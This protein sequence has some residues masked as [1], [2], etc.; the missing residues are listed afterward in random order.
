MQSK[1]NDVLFDIG[2]WH[3]ES[4]MH[5]LLRN[6][7]QIEEDLRKNVRGRSFKYGVA[8]D[9]QQNAKSISQVQRK[10]FE[11]K[12]NTLDPIV[13]T[14]RSSNYV[15]VL[16]ADNQK[17]IEDGYRQGFIDKRTHD[18]LVNQFSNKLMEARRTQGPKTVT[19]RTA[20][21]DPQD[22][23]F[24]RFKN[25]TE[26][27][28]QL[29]KEQYKR[30]QTP[31]WVTE[32]VAGA[33]GVAGSVYG[34]MASIA[35]A[36][37][38]MAMRLAGQQGWE[39]QLTKS[40][41]E[42]AK[43]GEDID[44]FIDAF[45]GSASGTTQA[46]AQ[47]AVI[48][49][50]IGNKI[51]QFAGGLGK[52]EEDAKSQ[53]G[54]KQRVYDEL[55]I[56][57]WYTDL[58]GDP[59]NLLRQKTRITAI[60]TVQQA[61]LAM[62]NIYGMQVVGNALAAAFMPVIK[63]SLALNLTRGA[64]MLLPTA[65]TAVGA[66]IDNQLLQD[67]G[68]PIGAAQRQGLPE[69]E[70]QLRQTIGQE[71]DMQ[72][73]EMA[74]TLGMF[75]LGAPSLYKDAGQLFKISKQLGKA[76]VFGRVAKINPAS[77]EG[78]N[79]LNE[80]SR[81]QSEVVPDVA[82]G[83]TN[84]FD[85][86]AR[87]VGSKFNDKVQA[88]T[89]EEWAKTA[90]LTAV[91]V[92][93]HKALQ[94]MFA[95]NLN[96]RT[97]IKGQ[98]RFAAMDAI[99]NSSFHA[100]AVNSRYETLRGGRS[101]NTQ[102]AQ[103]VTSMIYEM[104]AQEFQ[105]QDRNSQTMKSLDQ[106]FFEILN[107]K[108]Q[109]SI[110][111]DDAIK[112]MRVRGDSTSLPFDSP[113]HQMQVNK[114]LFPID[115]K[116]KKQAIANLAKQIEP[117]IAAEY[118]MVQKGAKFTGDEPAIAEQPDRKYYAIKI[119]ERNG[120]SEYMVY[121]K[122]FSDATL[123]RGEAGLE[124]VRIIDPIN[125]DKVNA[126]ARV[127]KLTNVM[128]SLKA[129]F[130]PR[131]NMWIKSGT[132]KAIGAIRTDGTIVIKESKGTSGADGLRVDEVNYSYASLDEVMKELSGIPGTQRLRIALNEVYNRAGLRK[133][134]A[135]KDPIVDIG[136]S[137]N[138]P[139]RLQFTTDQQINGRL[140]DTIGL[141]T[142]I[143]VYQ[144]PDGSVALG[145]INEANKTKL[146]PLT[147]NDLSQTPEL[148]TRTILSQA[149][150][151]VKNG[152][153]YIDADVHNLGTKSRVELPVEIQGVVREILESDAP[154][155]VKAQ[156]ILSVLVD[157]IAG[158]RLTGDKAAR[159]DSKDGRYVND[160]ELKAGDRVM[161]AS[162]ETN[163]ND[164]TEGVVVKSDNGMATVKDI[165]DPTGASY[166]LSADRFIL[167][168]KNMNREAM[169]RQF[170]ENAGNASARTLR[171]VDM[172]ISDEEAI[173]RLLTA[174]ETVDRKQQI[175][176]ATPEQIYDV[177]YDAI[178]NS[179]ATVEGIQL[180]LIEWAARN[181][182]E[183]VYD[184]MARVINDITAPGKEVPIAKFRK[185][186]EIFSNRGFN[187]TL[188]G[189]HAVWASVAALN[190]TRF[191]ATPRKIS[192]KSSMLQVARRMNMLMMRAESM[193][194]EALL[195][196]AVKSLDADMATL[197]KA[198]IIEFAQNLRGVA[199]HVF[200]YMQE[201]WH[202][203][204]LSGSNHAAQAT[205]GRAISAVADVKI[206][207]LVRGDN[208][209]PDSILDFWSSEAKFDKA[210]KDIRELIS[211]SREI[212][213]EGQTQKYTMS[214]VVYARLRNSG[215]EFLFHM[216]SDT[217]R[218]LVRRGL[219]TNRMEAI[220]FQNDAMSFMYDTYLPQIVVDQINGKIASGDFM[221]D[222]E[223]RT[224][225]TNNISYA[226]ELRAFHDKIIDGIRNNPNITQEQK[227]VA[228]DKVNSV[229]QEV[230]MLL[231]SDIDAL[232]E[233]DADGPRESRLRG[234]IVING[235]TIAE[236]QPANLK[237]ISAER[238]YDKSLADLVKESG[239]TLSE[240]AQR[241]HA[242]IFETFKSQVGKLFD[243]E[244]TFTNISSMIR[245]T[246]QYRDVQSQIDRESAKDSD[247]QDK[248]LL[249]ELYSNRDQVIAEQYD[250]FFKLTTT[251]L[252]MLR[253]MQPDVNL[254]ADLADS[255]VGALVFGQ[256]RS[257]LVETTPLADAIDNFLNRVS[258]LRQ[259]LISTD[260]IKVVSNEYEKETT[261]S[262]DSAATTEGVKTP[263]ELVTEERGRLR[264]IDEQIRERVRN[265]QNVDDLQEK[266]RV[267][268]GLL[269]AAIKTSNQ[270][271]RNLAD[272][273]TDINTAATALKLE[274]NKLDASSISLV[275]ML[276][277]HQMYMSLARTNTAT[278]GGISSGLTTDAAVQN[279]LA[280][281]EVRRL[282]S[283]FAESEAF[284][285]ASLGDVVDLQSGS[286]S[287]EVFADKYQINIEVAKSI[288][289]LDALN[290]GNKSEP[291]NVTDEDMLGVSPEK[292]D[293]S[294]RAFVGD[295]PQIAQEVI[296]SP[297]SFGGLIKIN[298]ASDQ[299]I[300]AYSATN[301]AGMRV[302]MRTMLARNF[303]YS[304]IEAAVASLAENQSKIRQAISDSYAEPTY[305]AEKLKKANGKFNE[306]LVDGDTATYIKKYIAISKNTLKRA[307][308][309]SGS[310]PSSFKP[311]LDVVIFE[312]ENL[313]DISAF[314][315]KKVGD[316]YKHLQVRLNDV[317][318]M[319]NA[320]E[321]SAFIDSV[322][323]ML[324][325]DTNNELLNTLLTKNIGSSY[326]LRLDNDPSFTARRIL[327]TLNTRGIQ[328]KDGTV[329]YTADSNDPVLNHS[330]VRL[331]HLPARMDD[332][333]IEVANQLV[334][335]YDDVINNQLPPLDAAK[336]D[337]ERELIQ[338]IMDVRD[339][340]NDYAMGD[341]TATKRSAE[342]KQQMERQ[343]ITELADNLANLYDIHANS[344]AVRHLEVKLNSNTNDFKLE[345]ADA[346][347]VLN[348]A[349]SSINRLL[350][351]TSLV[352][353]FL[354]EL[355]PAQKTYVMSYLTAKY[356]KQYYTSHNKI[357]LVNDEILQMADAQATL[358]V[359]KRDVYGFT[360]TL[361]T[362]QQQALGSLLYIGSNGN[363][364]YRSTLT[365]VHEMF[366]PLLTGM[367]DITQ[368]AF[369]DQL[370]AKSSLAVDAL[371]ELLAPAREA[372]ENRM[373]RD[374]VPTKIAEIQK[375]LD[376]RGNAELAL[377]LQVRIAKE[378][379]TLPLSEAL[380]PLKGLTFNGQDLADGW[381]SHGHEKFVTSMLNFITDYTVPI[382]KNAAASVDMATLEVFQQ[383]RSTLKYVMRQISHRRPLDIIKDVNGVPHSAWYSRV[384]IQRYSFTRVH[385]PKQFQFNLA[386]PKGQFTRHIDFAQLRK[387][388]YLR[389]NIPNR[390]EARSA[391]Q[392]P[393]QLMVGL[394]DSI[395]L[396]TLG[397]FGGS[398]FRFGFR[399]DGQIGDAAGNTWLP[400]ENGELRTY[401]VQNPDLAETVTVFPDNGRNDT[402]VI[403]S[404]SMPSRSFSGEVQDLVIKTRFKTF[405]DAK[406]A[407]FEPVYFD[408]NNIWVRG[409]SDE[410]G[411]FK[412]RV[413]AN[414]DDPR[415]L[416]YALAGQHEYA[417]I[418]DAPTIVRVGEGTS[419]KNFPSRFRFLVG[420]DAL[421]IDARNEYDPILVGYTQEFDPKFSALVYDITRKLGRVVYNTT[422]NVR[423][424]KQLDLQ[425]RL[426]TGDT[427]S[428]T[429]RTQTPLGEALDTYFKSTE[430]KAI[431]ASR[432]SMQPLVLDGAAQFEA[433]V[434]KM[435]LNEFSVEFDGEQVVT[436][437]GE[438]FIQ[439]I[440][441][442]INNV[443]APYIA[444]QMMFRHNSQDTYQTT[445]FTI[446]PDSVEMQAMYSA[447]K[448]MLGD[449][450]DINTL[451]KKLG[452]AYIA[453]NTR[454]DVRIAP[455][456]RIDRALGLNGIPDSVK[457]DDGSEYHVRDLMLQVLR[458]ER[459][460]MSNTDLV[461]VYTS[462]DNLWNNVLEPFISTGKIDAPYELNSAKPTMAMY[463]LDSLM[464]SAYG[465]S[466][467]NKRL[468]LQRLSSDTNPKNYGDIVNDVNERERYRAAVQ[469]KNSAFSEF[470]AVSHTLD[471]QSRELGRAL[472]AW[473]DWSLLDGQDSFTGSTGNTT[474]VV[475]RSPEGATFRVNLNNPRNFVESVARDIS[476]GAYIDA[477]PFSQ[478]FAL[479]D[480]TRRVAL[481]STTNEPTPYAL[482]DLNLSPEERNALS[483]SG[484]LD[485]VRPF[486]LSNDTHDIDGNAL[487]P[488]LRVYRITK[489][490]VGMDNP[491]SSFGDPFEKINVSEL[492]HNFKS[493]YITGE[494]QDVWVNN[495]RLLQQPV[496]DLLRRA[497]LSNPSL[498]QVARDN[499]SNTAVVPREVHIAKLLVSR[500]LIDKTDQVPD[501]W[502]RKNA[503]DTLA[504][505]Y[506]LE[507]DKEA[508]IADT[509][510][511]PRVEHNRTR[512]WMSDGIED[513]VYENQ[514]MTDEELAYFKMP[515]DLSPDQAQDPALRDQY[516]Q[517]AMS[518]AME[519]SLAVPS[520]KNI[521]VKRE[522]NPNI[523]K[524]GITAKDRDIYVSIPDADFDYVSRTMFS[525]SG[526][527][528]SPT[529]NPLTGRIPSGGVT[530]IPFLNNPFTKRGA[531]TALGIYHEMT[532]AA[533]ALILSGDFAR[534]MLQNFRLTAMNPKNFASQFWGLSA[535]LP[536]AWSPFNRTF[537]TPTTGAG[538]FL[539]FALGHKPELAWG[540]KQY[541]AKMFN[542]INKY[543]TKD[544][545]IGYGI[546]G[547]HKRTIKQSVGWKDLAEFGLKTTYG[548]WF[549]N[550]EAAKLIDPTID[551]FEMPIATTQAENIG[552]GVLARRI[553]FVNMWERAGALSTDILRVKSFLEFAA[554]VDQSM[555]YT[556]DYQRDSAKRDYAAF[557]NVIT[558]HPTGN[559]LMMSDNQ[560]LFNQ[561]L[562]TVYTSPNWFNSLMMQTYLPS[563]VKMY[564]AEGINYVSR[565]AT[566]K[567]DVY[568]VG[569][570]VIDTA[571][572]Q[573]WF[574]TL[575]NK[576]VLKQHGLTFMNV[577]S[578]S[579]VMGSV[580]QLMGLYAERRQLHEINDAKYVDFLDWKKITAP[581]INDQ[582]EDIASKLRIDQQQWWNPVNPDYG[583]VRAANTLQ[584]QMPQHYTL[585][586]RLFF[587]PMIAASNEP[588]LSTQEKVGKFAAELYKSNIEGRFG[589]P[590]QGLKQLASGRTYTEEAALGKAPGLKTW[591]DTERK[592]QKYKE[593][594]SDA[595]RDGNDAMAAKY[596]REIKK[597]APSIY[598]ASYPHI[599]LLSKMFPNGISR[600]A[601]SMLTNL[602]VQTALKDMEELGY[603]QF[604]IPVQGDKNPD[605]FQYQFPAFTRIF[606]LEGRMADYYLSDLLTKDERAGMSGKQ[607]EFLTRKYKY[608]YPNGAQ[609]MSRFGLSG[610]L[611]GIPDSGGYGKAPAWG[612]DKM[613]GVPDR[614]VLKMSTRNDNF[615]QKIK[616]RQPAAKLSV[617]SDYLTG[618]L[619]D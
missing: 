303:K 523:T 140:V 61:P 216:A 150:S 98:A 106:I 254:V 156:E 151:F 402:N 7:M 551:P 476:T 606:G 175:G 208:L 255:D 103:R 308:G 120:E 133:D 113:L 57:K 223:G 451:R 102:D 6:R 185:A 428:F 391:I 68:N 526:P 118:D 458:N 287:P 570:D 53:A 485:I 357:F 355:D 390:A 566:S 245:N 352:T 370:S 50:N 187:Q 111:A 295:A 77:I 450:M 608:N 5:Q 152:K 218:N 240:A 334:A 30:G 553:P 241:K 32:N 424:K 604:A 29:Q 279:I 42:K 454:G 478:M 243:I 22:V 11:Y 298:S 515:F 401:L 278:T 409:E 87:T 567:L 248:D 346:L 92:R 154:D 35:T 363:S 251:T 442:E 101:A 571:P 534:V 562:R 372:S 532:S 447:F 559:N 24:N 220:Q 568:G 67:I 612:V 66:G 128:R 16:N 427:K 198:K 436:E 579:M 411:W 501:R 305:M 212:E 268:Q 257:K 70:M 283:G 435:L 21:V 453:L 529:A 86:I 269:D 211:S 149:E 55:G 157:E 221:R 549:R 315:G 554:H 548:D 459:L 304:D 253:E 321:K 261:T 263:D 204:K 277:L 78:R 535:W 437:E 470:L 244:R 194:D 443:L 576:D 477:S 174:T 184:V 537:G 38:G 281:N 199:P 589:P 460:A 541:H 177:L 213:V 583:L 121:N 48:G 413:R 105:Q 483:Q 547:I 49:G 238:H 247:M 414:S 565:S 132:S 614:E 486:G 266:R 426:M 196:A 301:L 403:S 404:E 143:G 293:P 135:T 335:L 56:N 544:N 364:K 64:G 410:D 416:D 588:N 258:E 617:P 465:N 430:Y 456:T 609:V 181:S 139:S 382:S 270:S 28:G 125:Q 166:T 418:I 592:I 249:R 4:E 312:L 260:D 379:S 331:T 109:N 599:K 347:R 20:G 14:L 69:G 578:Q 172:T 466:V 615:L 487:S 590:I 560:N 613:R 369:M 13:N 420:Q 40:L 474:S 228:I 192:Q 144:L 19:G 333:P 545:V 107:G 375:L 114:N 600:Y 99:D 393:T 93:P 405:D 581:V 503:T 558:G 349:E 79:L 147:E 328:F 509:M 488:S 252:R 82:F 468:F 415:V 591:V 360:Q 225:Q 300:V 280:T 62:A 41:E 597:L 176:N 158:N 580:L 100:L 17:K 603:S 310:Y 506:L 513:G 209:L 429:L 116:F 46:L 392:S 290:P 494:D 329:A 236:D 229:V 433:A 80:Y 585:W 153:G 186:T 52:S 556:H 136:N 316:V 499:V 584:W 127:E 65:V 122:R 533:K 200:Y 75:G 323:K 191:A 593:L 330:K 34:Q 83:L 276:G 496:N 350:E 162:D 134:V 425:S 380:A 239:M 237:A 130:G 104:A 500:A 348:I 25:R 395:T 601:L 531:V 361:K 242:H 373:L 394:Q 272:Y 423:W 317:I 381:I 327:S 159:F 119:G 340:Y 161:F 497:F 539:N 552:E 482:R 493:G 452:D 89:A 564:A 598:N 96:K 345:V 205:L 163:P 449:D 521:I 575:R 164:I 306:M 594:L 227:D 528:G 359:D 282:R 320:S 339:A 190:G 569:F 115:P 605:L 189:V 9:P 285:T 607:F 179:R 197:S 183:G 307:T 91:A 214:D 324:S 292:I 273:Y 8:F 232:S 207:S 219:R 210:I 45:S 44:P 457:L 595:R 461:S 438:R 84:V 332:V 2:N 37:T 530:T 110:G 195:T 180:G 145:R 446:E 311:Y 97:D 444:E 419:Q 563:L 31:D 224:E 489:T 365:L 546:P 374:A 235:E 63:S 226:P 412:P 492:Q 561:T 138:F 344:H 353:R 596:D 582:G 206:R 201:L 378:S 371:N 543:G 407:G 137:E 536:N 386:D 385:N 1:E 421:G 215:L 555:E 397:D 467:E 479:Y 336:S 112:Q 354:S 165:N 338:T 167:S 377:A 309:L 73:Q 246:A 182:P 368:V 15:S 439:S 396:N 550:Y 490:G 217:T 577:F 47:P 326:D 117:A 51:S 522:T 12:K 202:V 256:D 422:G 233:Y 431:K 518:R 43:K 508:N 619:Y 88:P 507:G 297:D 440:S 222:V 464:N 384:P 610:L 299:A 59:D 188:Y 445:S 510:E 123:H 10:S 169:Q 262:E 265:N 481:R 126:S 108:S 512:T 358:F 586:K 538:K 322:L 520:P 313:P 408:K 71:G 356:K 33:K 448:S 170:D 131:D 72:N 525:A 288:A 319:S 388:D 383:M 23:D 517:T 572:E 129:E 616:D 203:A 94:P 480:P 542:Y 540:D 318:S 441:D 495:Q 367:D 60:N 54:E 557:L 462:F 274:L 455:N 434:A 296:T 155:S 398:R 81:L 18:N 302:L 505:Q 74:M 491:R 475:I 389:I 400:F 611:T 519:K 602:Q 259:R 527:T 376:S 267:I 387:N 95:N 160:V 325:P 432:T 417:Y 230:D 362:N 471:A 58:T 337:N 271:T 514:E 484:S 173:A 76:G 36:P 587:S 343:A 498:D 366:H 171:P 141:Q 178:V 574:R 284:S 294:L 341:S 511:N 250:S 39:E 463:V 193:S 618:R 289:S 85:P 291:V 502:K 234:N 27:F 472:Y 314:N 146:T 524:V 469:A 406:M 286:L 3:P 275:D 231:P 516:N 148:Q 264:L 573:K 473:K 26:F 504:R 351:P 142:P 399:H 90:L 342:V 124:D 168:D